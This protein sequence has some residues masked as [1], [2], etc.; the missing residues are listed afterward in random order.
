MA[1]G[2][3]W[4]N[5]HAAGS[6][7]AA[8]QAGVME[9][10]KVSLHATL[11]GQALGNDGGLVG[12][13]PAHGV[14]RQY[15]E[16]SDISPSE[17]SQP[18]GAGTDFGPGFAVVSHPSKGAAGV[19]PVTMVPANAAPWD[20]IG[21]RDGADGGAAGTVSGS[22]AGAGGGN[23]DSFRT[24]AGTTAGWDSPVHRRRDGQ[25]DSPHSSSA[26]SIRARQLHVRHPPRPLGGPAGFKHVWV[27]SLGASSGQTRRRQRDGRGRPLVQPV[28]EQLRPEWPPRVRYARL[29]RVSVAF[30][31]VRRWKRCRWQSRISRPSEP[32][33]TPDALY[34]CAGV[35]CG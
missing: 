19:S 16:P 28:D 25:I 4:S 10:G 35:A 5:G 6:A 22:V 2:G 11:E 17:A 8:G 12:T 9:A 26:G 18:G 32:G 24:D 21:P 31:L 7:A 3:V 20:H 15:F 29:P 34:G 33:R 13:S 14:V 27:E 23:S 30:P 1:K